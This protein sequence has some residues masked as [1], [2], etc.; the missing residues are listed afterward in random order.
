MELMLLT[1][2]FEMGL[3]KNGELVWISG[4]GLVSAKLCLMRD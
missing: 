1:I 3:M 4:K 2:A